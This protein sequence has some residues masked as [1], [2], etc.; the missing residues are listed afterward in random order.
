MVNRNVR[1]MRIQVSALPVTMV[2][3]LMT[4]DGEVGPYAAVEMC[5]AIPG[6]RILEAAAEMP[7]PMG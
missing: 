4:G 2:D 7:L 6:A 3:P 1:R 5:T